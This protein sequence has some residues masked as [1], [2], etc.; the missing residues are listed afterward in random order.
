MCDPMTI[1]LT[2]SAVSTVAQGYQAKQQGEFREGVG[3]FNTRQLENQAVQTRNV[4]VEEE[5][6]RRLQTAQL[7]SEQK[8]AF[9]AA[10]VDVGSGSALQIQEDTETIGEVDALRIRSNIENRAVAMESQ[11]AIE[12]ESGRAAKKA[13][14][15]MFALSLIEAGGVGL[16]GAVD[17]GLVSSKWF[18]P[19]SAST[20]TSGK[21]QSMGGL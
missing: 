8:A 6:R 19:D 12:L 18:T 5:N 9:A 1:A 10:G 21:I 11:A 16:M 2:L 20:V 4:G 17:A 13:G 3:E 14:E 7:Q 15:N